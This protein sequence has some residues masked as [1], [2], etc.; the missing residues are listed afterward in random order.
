L[1]VVE[2]SRGEDEPEVTGGTR[3]V[4]L[5]FGLFLFFFGLPFA[6]GGGFTLFE[7]LGVLPDSYGFDPFL[8]CFSLPF[9]GVGLAFVAGGI[10]MVVS[11]VLGKDMGLRIGGDDDDEDDDGVHGREHH[12][13][14]RSNTAFAYISREALL[15]QIHGTEGSVEDTASSATGPIVEEERTSEDILAPQQ[16]E[17]PGERVPQASQEAGEVPSQ[18]SETQEGGAGFWNLGDGADSS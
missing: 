12:E 10:K 16:A 15:A 9:L 18:P 8:V 1:T 14:G 13:S 17:N 4:M 7:G 2:E 6:A 5:G 3:I 11:G